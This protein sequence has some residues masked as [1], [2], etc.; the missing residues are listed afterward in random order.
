MYCYTE[1]PTY[2]ATD[3]RSAVRTFANEADALVFWAYNGS[4][5]TV[6]QLQDDTGISLDNVPVHGRAW[7]SGRAFD[8]G[9]QAYAIERYMNSEQTAMVPIIAPQAAELKP[10]QMPLY[11]F[12]A[13]PANREQISQNILTSNTSITNT[14]VTKTNESNAGVEAKLLAEIENL[15]RYVDISEDEL[16]TKSKELQERYN[17]EAKRRNQIEQERQRIVREQQREEEAQRIFESGKMTYRMLKNEICRGVS[18]LLQIPAQFSK[19]FV[20]YK[21]LDDN[22]LLD[23]PGDWN[24]FQNATDRVKEEQFRADRETY[25]KYKRGLNDGDIKEADIDDEFQKIYTAFRVLDESDEIDNEGTYEL[26]LE[27][28]ADYMNAWNDTKYG[29][30]NDANYLEDVNIDPLMRGHTPANDSDETAS[31]ASD[32]M[33]QK[34][35]AKRYNIT[36]GVN[37]ASELSNFGESFLDM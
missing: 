33:T 18:T 19:R 25:Y 7:E 4:Q 35:I 29:F 1:M 28:V 24:H 8:Y 12:N 36:T 6:H 34:E 14:S 27:L 20:I 26:F 30:N 3:G 16:N 5:G 2:L 37:A 23:L 22:G 17:E 31:N 21:E 10:V 15:K 13:A 11:N 9:N 32:N